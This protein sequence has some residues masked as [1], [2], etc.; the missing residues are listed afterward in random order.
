MTKIFTWS[1]GYLYQDHSGTRGESIARLDVTGKL[2]KKSRFGA[3]DLRGNAY[4]EV[5]NVSNALSENQ[6]PFI[7][8]KIKPKEEETYLAMAGFLG[9]EGYKLVYIEVGAE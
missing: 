7:A 8:M 4:D 2:Y 3:Y 5:R 9:D 6:T 1:N